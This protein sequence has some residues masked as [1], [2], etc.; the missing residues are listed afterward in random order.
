[1]LVERCFHTVFKT[2]I[3]ENS[4]TKEEDKEA[5]VEAK[6]ES[7]PEKL[8]PTSKKDQVIYKLLI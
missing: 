4:I 5:K 2:K 8:Q 1:M 7:L 6:K 3:V